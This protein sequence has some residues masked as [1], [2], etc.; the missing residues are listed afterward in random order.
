MLY[1]CNHILF[2]FDNLK[3]FNLL[4]VFLMMHITGKNYVKARNPAICNTPHDNSHHHQHHKQSV[5]EL[6]PPFTEYHMEHG[7]TE[8]EAREIINQIKSDELEKPQKPWC[9]QCTT[10]V[11]NYCMGPSF[12]RDHC[13]CDQRHVKGKFINYIQ[14]T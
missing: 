9:E 10:K 11:R 6:E 3:V 1:G 4:I 14:H 12:L 8:K 5:E 2:S 7:V 13:C